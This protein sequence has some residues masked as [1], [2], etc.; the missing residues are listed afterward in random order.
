VI[1]DGIMDA[2]IGVAGS[3][4]QQRAQPIRH[5]VNQTPSVYAED[6]WHVTP[7]LSLQLGLRYDALPN[8]WER[9]NFV[10]NFNPAHYS[11]TQA[12]YWN[13]NG[14]MLETGPGFQVMTVDGATSPVYLNGI[15]MAG[16]GGTP[17][18]LVTNKYDTLQ[19]RVGFSDDL[20]GDGKTVIRGGFGTFFERLQGNLIYNS[21]TVS[22][23]S[24]SPTANQVYFTTPQTSIQNGQ[25][26]AT[27]F[28]ASSEYWMAQS[29]PMPAVA[30]FSLGIQR[31]ITRSVVSVVQYV[32][33]VA[34][35]QEQYVHQNNFPVT[36]DMA[37]RAAGGNLSSYTSAG[38]QLVTLPPSGQ[39][40]TASNSNSFRSFQGYGDIVQM[41]NNTNG[42]Y[43]GFQAGI[44]IQNRWGLSGEADYTWSHEIDIQS[45]DN[46]CCTSNPWVIKYDK[47]S[48][49][50]D[51][52]QIF[53]AN[54]MYSIPFFNQS[55]G[56]V[57]TLAGGWRLAGTVVA[58]SG[59]PVPFSFTNGGDPIGLGGGYTNR[60]NVSAKMKYKKDVRGWF[61]TSLVSLPTAAWNGG[62][63]LGFGSAGKDA[64]T[65]PGRV[66]FNTS[67]YKGF[68]I[69][70]RVN[71][72]LRFESFNTFNHTQ[73]NGVNA[74][75]NGGNFG[76]INSTWDPRTLELGGK[77]T[78]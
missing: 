75:L 61:D 78:F 62:P 57:K 37:V 14:S 39:G 74:Q 10:A 6:N 21:A 55:H 31:E 58:Q 9:Q 63:N 3:Y 23:F 48:G 70:E 27:P 44:R 71:F 15:D 5:Y 40:N 29:F 32:G 35:H 41:A 36:T 7:R 2:L 26:A 13:S 22:P 56:W 50:L 54:Y 53:S 51:R 12:T 46:S 68:A 72:D 38:G 30:M 45:Y 34:W 28:F 65:G 16:Q 73:F 52:R 60:P 42:T 43:N 49:N 76:W 24:F 17:Q 11:P 25:T 1:G 33:N 69:T 47:G 18:G 20:T 67:L 4:Q 59:V 66:N 19:P 77:L 64:M 8:A